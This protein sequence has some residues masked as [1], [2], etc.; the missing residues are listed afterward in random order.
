MC[1]ISVLTAC[2]IRFA[3]NKGKGLQNLDASLIK[4][5]EDWDGVKINTDFYGKFSNF[6]DEGSFTNKQAAG[7]RN[8]L[9]SSSRI[10]MK[11][12]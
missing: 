3:F 11:W 9:K 2:A 7:G 8:K 6:N 5:V 10:T 12:Y 4:I 1:S